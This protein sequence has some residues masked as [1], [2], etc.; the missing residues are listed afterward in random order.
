MNKYSKSISLNIA[1]LI[2]FNAVQQKRRQ[3]RSMILK[4]RHSKKKREYVQLP[5]KNQDGIAK[6]ICK[7][8]EEKHI[9]C[10]LTENLFCT[11]CN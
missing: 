6:Q 8:F 10:P 9:V 4:V 3:A 11:G 7:M 1:Q 2:R 5:E